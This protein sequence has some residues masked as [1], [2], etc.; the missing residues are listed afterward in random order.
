[1]KR[2]VFCRLACLALLGALTL[3]LCA[4]P[5]G[6][7]PPAACTHVYENG[8]C[9]LCGDIQA[10]EH[11]FANGVCTKCGIPQDCA[12]T[13]ENGECT[14]CGAA[15]PDYT[16]V[17][18]EGVRIHGAGDSLADDAAVFTPASYDESKASGVAAGN[19]V[20][21][22]LKKMSAA[23]VY[24][25]EGGEAKVVGSNAQSVTYDGQGGTILAPDGILFSEASKLTIRNMTIVG[26]MTVEGTDVVFENC[27]IVGTVTV[28]KS[29]Q[30]VVFNSCRVEGAFA[31]AGSTVTVLNSYVA[32]AGNGIT[33]TGNG[34][35]VENC[36]LE[37]TGTAVTI[38]GEDCAVKYSTLAL[39][40]K[41][42]GISFEKG[43]VNGFAA[44]NVITGAQ[45][46]IVANE[47]FNT[48]AVC[49]SMISVYGSSSTNLYICDNQMGGRVVAENNNYLLADGNAFP[50]D[51]K[52]HASVSVANTNVNGDSMMDV[53]ARLE[54]GADENLLPHVNRDQFVGMAR[55]THVRDTALTLNVTAYVSE[56]LKTESFVFVAPGAYV[57]AN[58]LAING[59]SDKTVYA[60][61]A[62]LEKPATP[63][64]NNLT[65]ILRITSSVNIT[66]KGMQCGYE[67]PASGQVHVLEKLGNNR[68]LAVASAGMINEFSD[69]NDKYYQVATYWHP[70][71]QG[72]DYVYCDTTIDGVVKQANGL[73]TV[74]V[75][76]DVYDLVRPGDIFTCRA[77]SGGS[78]VTTQADSDVL[79][80]DMIVYGSSGGLCTVEIRNNGQTTYYRVADTS[81]SG[82]VIDKATYERYEALEAEYDVDLGVYIDGE[83]RY[84]GCEAFISSI[85]ATHVERCA[86]GSKIVSCLFENMCDDGTNQ[87]GVH[88]RLAGITIEG[89]VATIT[90][91]GNLSEVKAGRQDYTAT[92][93]CWDFAEGDRIFIYTSAGQLICDTETLSAAVKVGTKPSYGID[94]TAEVE[95]RSVTVPASAISEEA[96]AALSKYNLL[97]DH[98]REGNKV[99][100]DNMS[101][102]SNGFEIDNTMI[103]NTRS[104]GLLI[105][106]SNGTVTNCT[107]RNNAKCGVAIIYEIYWGESG[108]SENILVARNLFDNTSYS[109]ASQVRYRHA[110]LIIMGLGGGKV[111]EEYLLYKNIDII[112]NKF[113]NRN[114]H[115]NRYAIYLQAVR[116]V[117]I[118]DN[119]FGTFEGESEDNWAGAIG[120]NGAMNVK[121]ENNVYSEFVTHDKN[122]FGG[123]YKNVYGGDVDGF[124]P[125]DKDN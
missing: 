46:S 39:S 18:G 26:N 79:F 54:V 16:V 52:S 15:D 124:I 3:A 80:K 106:S 2:S 125:K 97:D 48:V 22:A 81:R 72:M 89:D 123:F 43:T 4:C 66:V 118:E 107:F 100:V 33:A 113:I 71:S 105:K 38:S 30:G 73:M 51:G 102:S 27:K 57:A 68:V 63:G 62:Y 23:A 116:D 40:E 90:Y 41:D 76:P 93:F 74:S 55:K 88:A 82:E 1:M 70:L 14:K 12:H 9:T 32:F 61:G 34:L 64:Q 17:Y 29:A 60:Y 35:L 36:R 24:R 6:V 103:K 20:R 117:V 45:K 109:I 49:N 19:F 119:D 110:P 111:S 69:S 115:V 95:H 56:L 42:T 114:V 85:D 21:A 86:I 121:I 99:L 87:K 44:M 92:G 28:K 96:L 122:F 108:V 91:K 11:T 50:E 59:R 75:A 7:T 84:R 94:L 67:E 58:E 101:R 47:V 10:C 98:Y 31:F 37:G 112:G 8:V 53:D 13:Y 120:F 78:T 77:R 5:G 104:R 83:G 65:T 25:A